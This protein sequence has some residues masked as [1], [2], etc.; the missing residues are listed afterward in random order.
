MNHYG[1]KEMAAAFRTVRKNTIQVA[2]DIPEEK[3][4][5]QATPETRTVAQTLAHI[6]YSPEFRIPHSRQQDHRLV[7]GEFSRT[8]PEDER[9]GIQTAQQSRNHRGPSLG[10]REICVVSRELAGRVPC[11]NAG[12]A[13]G[14]LPG[15]ADA[16]RY[17][18]R[19]RKNTKCTIALNSW[20]WSAWW[21]SCRISRANGRQP[22][23]APRRKSLS[24]LPPFRHRTRPRCPARTVP[25]ARI[26]C[27]WRAGAGEKAALVTKPTSAPFAR[28]FV[29]GAGGVA[30]VEIFSDTRLRLTCP[31]ER[32]RSTIS[33]PV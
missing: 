23:P 28:S 17:A 7:D 15:H 6:A 10:G 22:W 4:G 12:H 9:R 32:T 25:G 29:P 2:E 14:R 5:F 1:G 21:E 31:R 3:Y 20:S 30:P 18:A 11:G 13:A 16:F 33:C 24:E 26:P 8:D 27:R 19:P